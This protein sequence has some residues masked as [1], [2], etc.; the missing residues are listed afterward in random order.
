MFLLPQTLLMARACNREQFMRFRYQ[1][2]LVFS[3]IVVH[4][5]LHVLSAYKSVLSR[6]CCLNHVEDECIMHPL[7]VTHA[8]FST[9]NALGQAASAE[10]SGPSQDTSWDT[11]HHQIHLSVHSPRRG[12]LTG[13]SQ[14]NSEKHNQPD[15]FPWAK[16]A[17]RAER[18]NANCSGAPWRLLGSHV[19]ETALCKRMQGQYPSAMRC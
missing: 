16:N 4:N 3:R 14:Q 11:Q 17:S 12:K 5:L 15:V 19:S 13:Y 6:C 1:C 9:C 2:W 7:T 8:E 10:S 18:S